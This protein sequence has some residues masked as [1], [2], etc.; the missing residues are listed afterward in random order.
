MGIYNVPVEMK[1]T[2]VIG[3]TLDRYMKWDINED[4]N[5]MIKQRFKTVP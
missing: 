3:E 5:N 4:Q 1:E 2:E